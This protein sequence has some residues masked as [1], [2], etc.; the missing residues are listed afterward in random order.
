M[1]MRH[2]RWSLTALVGSLPAFAAA[3]PAAAPAAQPFT[4]G[5]YIPQDCWMYFHWAH[6]PKRE[7]ID[8]HWSEVFEA[9]KNS[10]IDVELKRLIGGSMPPARRAEFDQAWDTTVQLILGVRWGELA[11]KEV[12]FAE[13]LGSIS[14][15]I[16]AL[17]RSTPESV[18]GNLEGLRAILNALA[19]LKEGSAVTES[20]MHG[21]QL[22]SLGWPGFPMQ[23]HLFS[24]DDI[25]GLIFG[26]QAVGDVLALLGGG[27]EVTAIVDSPRFKNAFAELPPPEDS[28]TFFD[29]QMFAGDLERMFET[30]FSRAAAKGRHDDEEARRARGLIMSLF[31]QLDFIDYVAAVSRTDGLRDTTTATTRLRAEAMDKPLCRMLT[32][33]QPFEP[34]D[35]FIP[36]QATGFSV[37]T[38]LNLEEPYRLLL[39]LV[40]DQLPGG[41]GLLEKWDRIQQDI[42]FNVQADLFSWWSGEMVSVN[43]PPAVRGP[44]ASKD[45]AW[46]IRV[47]DARLAAAK[48]NAGIDRLDALLRGYDVASLIIS[49]IQDVDDPGVLL[50]SLEQAGLGDPA[51]PD[52]TISQ[53]LRTA[54]ERQGVPLAPDATVST[55]GPQGNRVIS[56][57]DLSYRIGPEGNQLHVYHSRFRSITHPIIAIQGIKL[58]VGVAGDYLVI[59]SSTAAINACLATAA[60]RAPSIRH[61]PRFQ[62]EGL[63]PQGPVCGAAFTDLSQ[64]G[65]EMGQVFM[66]LGLAGTIIPDSPDAR[67]M[68]AVISMLGRL[69]PAF[70]Q[71][72]FFSSSA[73]VCTFDGRGWR[74]EQVLN[75]K[76]APPPPPAPRSA[77]ATAP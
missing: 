17:C 60:G 33:Q 54:F 4:L 14:F 20:R 43:L 32:G 42:D 29:F 66:M 12:V 67:P 51:Q 26:E 58:I 62:K 2:L 30:M 5:Q 38:F 61:T 25:V 77:N 69:G 15:E 10:G 47:K 76:P 41:T 65:Q 9:V 22:W 8:A 45:L 59:G 31:D 63:L 70:A 49:E 18:E 21:I 6:P 1:A 24:R 28:R 55:A 48:V 13:R 40:G 19:A 34:F 3:A 44:F 74:T 7:T 11:A 72:D 52:G 36:E 73:S 46:F 23:L 68:K 64:L 56:S 53:P 50:F 16:I 27:P 57:G 71:L 39:D 37:S 35:R 75:Y